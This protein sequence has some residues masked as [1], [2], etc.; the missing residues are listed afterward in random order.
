VFA[1]QP[2]GLGRAHEELRAVRVGSGVSHRQ[3][4]GAGVLELEVLVLELGSVDGLASV[5]LWLVKSPLWH[6]K[7]GMTI[8]RDL[9]QT[10]R[11]RVGR[12]LSF[13]SSVG[14]GT[15]PPP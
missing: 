15:P 1:I 11:H 8:N 6:M 5:P 3:D 10:L 14:I 4:T 12:V 9:V 2:L 7:L 13:F